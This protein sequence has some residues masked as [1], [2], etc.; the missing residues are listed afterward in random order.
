MA[1]TVVLSIF[2]RP[3][4]LVLALLLLCACQAPAAATGNGQV[5]QAETHFVPLAV[6]PK[7]DAAVL[8]R[9][10]AADEPP[11]EATTTVAT[12]LPPSPTPTAPPTAVPPTVTPAMTPSPHITCAERLPDDD[13]FTVV[14][15]E[16]GLSKEYGPA[17]LVPIGELLPPSVTLGYP[18]EVREEVLGP[19]VQ[20]IK[21]MQAEGLQPQVQSGYRS[22]IAQALAWD[23]WNRLYPEHAAIISAPPGHS[24]HQLGTVIDF[25]SPELAAL[26]GQPGIEFHTDFAKTSEGLWLAAHAHEYGFTMSYTL[27]AFEVSGFYYEPWHFR[28]VGPEMATELHAQELTLTEYQLQNAPAPCLP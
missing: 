11:P 25:G 22:Y 16:Y 12:P 15:L 1:L 10:L 3:Q 9:A 18:T 28:Y 4:W 23:K 14:T 19:L 5:A 2:R 21:D 7:A 6:A 24:E 20:M 13:L 27:A 8:A 17:D 26:V